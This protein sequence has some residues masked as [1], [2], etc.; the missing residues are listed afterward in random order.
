ME[1]IVRDITTATVKPNLAT[2][3]QETVVMPLNPVR[4]PFLERG[5][6]HGRVRTFLQRGYSLLRQ[7]Q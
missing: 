5:Y 6:T 3:L 7:Q 1:K 4:V 2:F